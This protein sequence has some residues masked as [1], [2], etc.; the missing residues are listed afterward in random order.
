MQAREA[1]GRG[2]SVSKREEDQ[3]ACRS[4][5]T[6][7]GT[8]E[9]WRP[10]CSQSEPCDPAS[11]Q[12]RCLMSARRERTRA[13]GRDREGTREARESK[14]VEGWGKRVSFWVTIAWLSCASA[15]RLCW[16]VG[17]TH[18]K[19]ILRHVWARRGRGRGWRG[20]WCGGSDGRGR[21]GEPRAKCRGLQVGRACPQS[22]HGK[23]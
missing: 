6:R 8:S 4:Q 9:P 2:A 16:R 1:E 12:G 21:R 20:W 13:S 7:I 14:Q 10:G 3:R 19:D 11:A 18:D 15:G 5:R 22:S 23:T 17:R